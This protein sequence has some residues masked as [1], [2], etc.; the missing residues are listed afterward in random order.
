MGSPPQGFGNN[1]LGSSN[2]GS[3]NNN[4]QGR[5]GRGQGRGGRGRGKIWCQVCGRQGHMAVACYHYYDKNFQFPFNNPRTARLQA[6]FAQ[7]LSQASNANPFMH[8]QIAQFSATCNHGSSI[9]QDSLYANLA[10]VGDSNW[11]FDSGAS[12]HVT[13]DA[14]SLPFPFEFQG[15]DKLIVGNGCGLPISPIG[16]TV[17]NST[18][19]NHT[20]LLKDV[21]V[22]LDITKNFQVLLSLLMIIRLSLSLTLMFVV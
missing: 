14:S 4:G 22:V 12:N 21:L 9:S 19:S 13:A 6:Q 20:L 2:S 1:N 5:G 8:A 11:Y 18:S 16:S 15:R 3:G 10:K 17:L 7:F